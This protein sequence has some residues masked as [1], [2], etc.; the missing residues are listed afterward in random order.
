MKVKDLIKE[1]VSNGT[2]GGFYAGPKIPIHKGY[3]V[4]NY[5]DETDGYFIAEQHNFMCDDGQLLLDLSS[6]TI[7]KVICIRGDSRWK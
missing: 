4:K 1:F 3:L 6:E 5:K 7:D 2:C